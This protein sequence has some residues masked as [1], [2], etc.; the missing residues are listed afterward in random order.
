MV[1]PTGLRVM[2]CDGGGGD[3]D[4]RSRLAVCEELL[5]TTLGFSTNIMGNIS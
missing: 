4:G 3:D 5:N 2:A 1:R